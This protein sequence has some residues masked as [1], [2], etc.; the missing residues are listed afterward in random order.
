MEILDCKN[1]NIKISKGSITI[2]DECGK[3]KGIV[4]DV[5]HFK[6]I[7]MNKQVDYFHILKRAGLWGN[8]KVDLHN[9]IIKD[10]TIY[11]FRN[12]HG[13]EILRRFD[14]ELAERLDTIYKKA[15]ENGIEVV[16]AIFV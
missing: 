8:S 7:Q 15:S 12:I 13:L 10:N 14:S 2:K 11:L 3:T 1:Q 5:R 16:E 6:D 4:R 9:V